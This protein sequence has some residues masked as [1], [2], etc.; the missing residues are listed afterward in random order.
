MIRRLFFALGL[1]GLAASVA[2]AD[3]AI[4]RIITKQDAAR[5]QNYEITRKTALTDARE[6]GDKQDIDIIN[7]VIT[8]RLARFAGFDMTGDWQCRTIKLGGD[9]AAVVYGW[10]KCRVTDDGAG[11]F[12]NKTSGSQRT[13]GRFYDDSDHRLIYLGTQFVAGEQPK[14]YKTDA[15]ADQVGYAFRTAKG[16]RIEFPEPAFESKLDILEL[17]R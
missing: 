4:T 2:Q 5:L 6:N 13:Q 7:T 10:F 9:P 14:R 16:F 11:W 3:G 1:I 17:R 15:K 8:E 12:L